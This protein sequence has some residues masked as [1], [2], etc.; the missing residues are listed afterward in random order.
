M[1]FS[2]LPPVVFSGFLGNIFLSAGGVTTRGISDFDSAKGEVG[3]ENLLGV[4]VGVFLCPLGENLGMRL[5]LSPE[6][7]E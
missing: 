6:G 4:E 5:F 7:A 1:F 2:V 3:L